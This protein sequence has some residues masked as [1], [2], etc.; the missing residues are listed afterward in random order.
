MQVDLDTSLITRIILQ[1]IEP[2]MARFVELCYHATPV[3]IAGL[4]LERKFHIVKYTAPTLDDVETDSV[5]E[6]LPD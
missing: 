3:F 5:K 6:E 1:V 4:T 2:L